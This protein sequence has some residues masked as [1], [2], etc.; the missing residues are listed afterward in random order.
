M[1]IRVAPLYSR[2][3]ISS[4]KYIDIYILPVRGP[5][6]RALRGP[7]RPSQIAMAGDQQMIMIMAMIMMRTFVDEERGTADEVDKLDERATAPA[8]KR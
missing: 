4:R 8:G 7:H 1:Q 2:H 5:P 6:D 3:A